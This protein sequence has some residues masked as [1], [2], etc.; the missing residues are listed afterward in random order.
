MPCNRP[1]LTDYLKNFTGSDPID[2]VACAYAQ[3]NGAGMGF[4]LFA[5]FLISFM[6]L[7]LTLKAQHP[8][9]ILIAAMLS[10]GLFATLVP[11]IISKIAAIVLFF[12]I[13]ALGLYVYNRA[14]SEL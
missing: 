1:A 14:K 8:A 6:G 4:P 9:P 3:D 12:G 10:A 2:A 5:M 7:G 13:A 11:G